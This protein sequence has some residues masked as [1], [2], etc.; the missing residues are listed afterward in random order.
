MIVH[1]GASC[2][3]ALPVEVGPLANQD[4]GEV[5]D[6]LHHTVDLAVLSL[7][8]SGMRLSASANRLYT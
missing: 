6:L 1:D 8:W 7:A 4:L 3:I 2:R 5:I